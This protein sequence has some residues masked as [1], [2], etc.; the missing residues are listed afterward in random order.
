MFRRTYGIFY[1]QNSDIFASLFDQLSGYY[2][3]G[4]VDLE[5]TM[6]AFYQTLYRRMFQILN[7]PYHF[8]SDYLDCIS[9]HMEPLEP[10]GDVPKKMKEQMSP[11]VECTYRL[12][13]MYYCSSCQGIFNVKPC[14]SFCVD[15]VADCLASHIAFDQHWNNYLDALSDLV[16]L[17]EGPYNIESLVDPIDIKISDAIMIFQDKGKELSDRVFSDCGRPLPLRFKRGRNRRGHDIVSVSFEDLKFGDLK[18]SDSQL[19]SA[20]GANLERLTKDI[21]EKVLPAKGFWK[22]LPKSVC[23][24]SNAVRAADE[25]CWN[26]TFLERYYFVMKDNLTL[27]SLST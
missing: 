21:K 18:T 17:L 10:F 7:Q 19:S 16:K 23:F 14:T 24:E 8:D 12:T 2:T 5:K 13:Q 3:N 20:A 1:D 9:K 27:S 22:N 25:A 6:D 26:G 15:V 4:N 11:S